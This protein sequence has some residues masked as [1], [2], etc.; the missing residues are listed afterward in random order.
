MFVSFTSFEIIIHDIHS[1]YYMT[2]F[3]AAKYALFW[4]DTSKVKTFDTLEELSVYFKH[5]GKLHEVFFLSF[6]VTNF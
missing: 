6:L 5:P 4:R 2:A 3:I 1:A